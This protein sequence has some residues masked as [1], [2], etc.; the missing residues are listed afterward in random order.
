MIDNSTGERSNMVHSSFFNHRLKDAL[1]TAAKNFVHFNPGSHLAGYY[2]NLVKGGMS[3]TESRKRVARALVRV[4]F[5][6]LYS[7]DENT[8]TGVTE[9][10]DAEREE[11]RESDMASGQVRSDKNHE[12]N[13]SL[14]PLKNHDTNCDGKVNNR[15]A[16]REGKEPERILKKSA[17]SS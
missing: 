9:C 15:L 11:K 12:S 10:D 6:V 7:I 17:K 4:F 14:S 16:Q 2:R 3:V 13:I 8:N 1:M 5:R